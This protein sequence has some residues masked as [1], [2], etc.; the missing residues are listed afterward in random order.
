MGIEGPMPDRLPSGEWNK[1]KQ[2]GFGK[3]KDGSENLEEAMNEGDV[4]AADVGK[5]NAENREHPYNFSAFA[6]ESIDE[7]RAEN[8]LYQQFAKKMPENLIPSILEGWVYTTRQDSPLQGQYVHMRAFLLRGQHIEPDVR[9]IAEYVGISD[10]EKIKT[11]DGVLKEEFSFEA[12]SPLL[13]YMIEKHQ[14]IKKNLADCIWDKFPGFR[15]KE[16]A[17]EQPGGSY[18]QSTGS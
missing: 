1:Q 9:T 11:L 10:Q 15:L 5:E 18:G 17:A 3:N 2:E 4:N 13:D 12:N 8:A 14:E 7:K 16:A 6:A